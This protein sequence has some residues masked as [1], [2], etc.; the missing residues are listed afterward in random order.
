MIKI[1]IK[2]I[3]VGNSLAN[4]CDLRDIFRGYMVENK[5]NIILKRVIM[6]SANRKL[7]NKLK[8]R[9]MIS[10][11][12]IVVSVK[13]SENRKKEGL[14]DARASKCKNKNKNTNING[15][16]ERYSKSI[17]IINPC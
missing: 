12:T 8:N 1:D 16:L 15:T 3:L 14:T 2:S 6:K 7:L 10:V 4:R 9:R 11:R 17:G 13:I 5:P